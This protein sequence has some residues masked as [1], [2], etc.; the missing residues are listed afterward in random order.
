[1]GFNVLVTLLYNKRD[2]KAMTA[3]TME[4]TTAIP[5]LAVSNCPIPN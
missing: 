3:K 5:A 4:G 2:S 1:L